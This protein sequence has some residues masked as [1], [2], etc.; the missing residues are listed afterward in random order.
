MMEP[1]LKDVKPGD[2]LIALFG[3]NGGKIVTVDRVTKT[4]AVCGSYRFRLDN[5]FVP[6]RY[7][8]AHARFATADDIE[9]IEAARLCS[10]IH[11]MTKQGTKYKWTSTTL[12]SVLATLN[13]AAIERPKEEG[14]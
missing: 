10:A 4:Q 3:W 9:R 2:K 7:S 13:Y 6:G 5:G 11:E 8:R 1:T 14:K 12:E